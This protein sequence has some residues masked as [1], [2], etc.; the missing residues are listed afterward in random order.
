LSEESEQKESIRGKLQRLSRPIALRISAYFFQTTICVS[1][2]MKKA[3][4]TDFGFSAKKI[5]MIH[6]GVSL[7]GFYP[8]ASNRSGMRA[9]LGLLP[10]EFVL[11]CVARLSEQKGIGILL[12]AVAKVL[13]DGIRCKCIIVGEGPLRGQLQNQAQE[14]NL[15]RAVFFEGFQQDIRSYLQAGSAFILTSRTEGLPLSILEAM[16][17]GLPS[18][19]TDVGG[20]AEAVSHQVN[21]LV[22]PPGSPEAVAE[23]ISYLAT[24][25][26]EC[27]RMSEMAR[28]I[29]SEAFDIENSMAEIKRVI[30]N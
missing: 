2:A 7:S 29:A 5:K 15:S 21:G 26:Q 11:V 6:N 17:C 18:I 25:P 3:L 27:A 4:V 1:Q 10:D 28:K 16:G 13:R 22:V 23:A 24:H 14:L 12:Q 9:R 8:S 19:V 20:N 30:L